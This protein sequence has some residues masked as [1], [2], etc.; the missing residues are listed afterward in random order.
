MLDVP[1]R[2]TTPRRSRKPTSASKAR[3]P[4]NWH[5]CVDLDKA[6]RRTRRNREPT[7]GMTKTKSDA[8][9]ATF[10]RRSVH[11]EALPAPTPSPELTPTPRPYSVCVTSCLAPPEPNPPHLCIAPSPHALTTIHPRRTRVPEAV[12]ASLCEPCVW[13]ND[14]LRLAPRKLRSETKSGA[15]QYGSHKSYF[16]PVGLRSRTSK[17]HGPQ[18]LDRDDRDLR[19]V[20]VGHFH[21]VQLFH[22]HHVR[23]RANT[24]SRR[25]RARV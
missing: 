16:E 1:T 12:P 19:K 11:L 21:H 20:R 8:C 5:E 24:G 25:H 17:R 2:Q 6:M 3:S 23:I 14:F 15:A 13:Q 9:K 7:S 10:P 22:L 4:I 18:M